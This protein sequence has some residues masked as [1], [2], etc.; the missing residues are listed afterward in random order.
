MNFLG[1]IAKSQIIIGFL[2]FVLFWQILHLVI[3][4]HTIP[5]PIETFAYLFDQ[6]L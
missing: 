4:T 3:P 6:S 5:S 2:S 1:K